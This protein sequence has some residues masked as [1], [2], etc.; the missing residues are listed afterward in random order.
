MSWIRNR[1]PESGAPVC[2]GALFTFT[3]TLASLRKN[4]RLRAGT[5]GLRG[6]VR[7]NKM[8][9]IVANESELYIERGGPAYRLMQW[10][11]LIRGDDPSV[12][13]RIVA[14]LAVTCVPLL[15][16][17]CVGRARPRADSAGVA[18]PGLRRVRAFPRRGA[19]SLHRRSD[20]WASSDRRGTAFPA[21]R[22]GDAGGLSRLR[23]SDPTLGAM[24][25]VA[26]G[27]VGPGG[28][29]RDRSV[30][31]HRRNRVRGRHGEL[32]HRRGRDRQRHP[33]FSRRTLVSR[34]FRA[35]RFSSSGIVG[36]G[37]SSSGFGFSTT[38]AG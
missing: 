6:R 20:H 15:V 31:V 29:C 16:L 14:F 3:F 4:P 13:R 27:G 1:V 17:S 34:R 18:T 28:H 10:I 35:R 24:A 25:R 19:A 21:G 22:L 30:D 12:E 26:V 11:G 9:F 32:A 5:D 23:A 7:S 37:G 8:K 36:S 33:S 2:L 38:L